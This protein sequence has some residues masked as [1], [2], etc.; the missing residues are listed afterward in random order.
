M[1]LS[2][3]I[4]AAGQG[5]RMRSDTPKILHPLA[6]RP[7]LEHVVR[8]ARRLP[9]RAVH[10]VYG[11][12][13]EQVKAQLAHLRA[14]WVEQAQ[15][16]GTGHAVAQALPRVPDGDTVLVLYGDVPLI[17]SATLQRLM[18]AARPD[19]LALLTAHLKNPAGYGR[20][21][22]SELGGVARIVE[23][24]EADLDQR[25]ITEINTGMLAAPAARLKRWV[26]A[27]DNRNAKGE[28]Y[29]TDV[30]SQAV[31]EGVAVHTVAP[32]SVIE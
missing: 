19:A 18:A 10:V 11:H 9:A 2:I 20:I 4:L 13:G 5:T 15:Q 27:L 12:G 17:A 22:R 7:L 30:V 21:V 1:D 8:A 28:F 6:G 32:D 25:L 26:A 24:A 23:E 14:D 29:L 31:R 3:I 16:L